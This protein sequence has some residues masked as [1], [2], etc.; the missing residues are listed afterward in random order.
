MVVAVR[1]DGSRTIVTHYATR[2]EAEAATA[3]ESFWIDQGEYG[4]EEENTVIVIEEVE[5]SD[6]EGEESGTQE[7]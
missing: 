7:D 3:Q 4:E 1:E 6:M 5:I 2:E